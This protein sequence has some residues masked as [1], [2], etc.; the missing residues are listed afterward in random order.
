MTSNLPPAYPAE[1]YYPEFIESRPDD[2]R[3]SPPKPLPLPPSVTTPNERKQ[4]PSRGK[5]TPNKSLALDVV[6]D[7]GL[8]DADITEA[9]KTD[10]RK[11]LIR[12]PGEKNIP[13]LIVDGSIIQQAMQYTT[14]P[15]TTNLDDVGTIEETKQIPNGHT[16]EDFSKK[17]RPMETMKRPVQ[18]VV[19][20]ADDKPPIDDYW[21]KEIR[22]DDEGVV[23]IEVRLVSSKD[24]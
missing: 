24:I 3:R 1:Y 21:K 22:I 20:F 5:K 6:T 12:D 4:L 18:Q 2:P 11:N 13:K 19:R 9:A 10:P 16:N 7:H 15:I 17:I 14:I 8:P 23:A